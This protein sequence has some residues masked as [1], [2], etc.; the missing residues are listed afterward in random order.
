MKKK[1]GYI[2]IFSGIVLIPI[3]L[4]MMFD[5]MFPSELAE[6]FSFLLTLVLF[7]TGFAL[8][9][10]DAEP[11]KRKRKAR[12]RLIISLIL[13]LLG[14]NMKVNHLY[15]AGIVFINGVLMFCF[16]YVPLLVL[17]RY[18]K[19]KDFTSNKF[20]T[21]TVSI[22]DLLSIISVSYGVL[23]K[24]MHWPLAFHFLVFGAVLFGIS[25]IA[26]NRIFRHSLQKSR[27][28]EIKLNETLK[29]LKTK[30]EIIE[31]KNKEITDS[32]NYAKRIQSALLPDE[33]D[34]KN[35]FPDSFILFHP[36]DIVSG[37]FYW[38]AKTDKYFF[39]AT[40][41]C[42]GH[43]VPGGFMSMLGSSFLN[44]II[45]ENHNYEP[46]EILNRLREKVISALKQTGEAGEN[47]DGMD[48]V[49][50]R[51]SND[52]TKL[53]YAA[54]NNEFYIIRNNE[55]LFYSPD[56]QP[57]GYIGEYQKPFSQHEISLEKG[58]IIYSFTDGFA[59]QFGGE[60]GKKLK[61]KNM[62]TLLMQN[63]KKNLSEQKIIYFQFIENWRGQLEQNDDICVIGIK[64]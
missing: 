51:I 10:F 11:E 62:E 13:V 50:I 39:Y 47:K 41:D 25:F 59:D 54:A 45:V 30:H 49:L 46:A 12:L 3:L 14:L 18:E 21:L 4:W 31:E 2:F 44:E 63:H 23:G 53:C 15:G 48:I 43:G 29:E 24:A 56:K 5:G 60:K 35:I 6:I 37:D 8:I 36:K 34:F 26:W 64:I 55:M 42:T 61:Y 27:E 1:A 20:H 22:A 17:S 7:F 19:W 32:I 57:I 16:S 52:F 33:S 58:D 9:V 28:S 40:A 38:M